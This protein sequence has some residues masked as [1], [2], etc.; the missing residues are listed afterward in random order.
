MKKTVSEKVHGTKVKASN[1]AH[2]HTLIGSSSNNIK[3]Q[4]TASNTTC[5]Q[6]STQYVLLA[7]ASEVRRQLVLGSARQAGQQEDGFSQVGVLGEVVL[8]VPVGIVVY[9]HGHL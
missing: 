6:H 4:Q 2:K 1:A 5:T 9:S 7:T 3:Q 8:L